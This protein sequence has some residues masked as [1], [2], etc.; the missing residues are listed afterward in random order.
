MEK[1]TNQDPILENEE[2]T[3]QESVVDDVKDENVDE[4]QEGSNEPES[5][6]ELKERLEALEKKNKELYGRLKRTATKT[7]KSKEPSV[8]NL[9]LM[10]HFSSGGT[11]DEVDIINTIMRGDG[12]N[13]NEAKKSP[14]YVSYLE[15]KKADK[16]SEDSQVNSKRVASSSEKFKKGLTPDE[17][18]EAWK[19]KMATILK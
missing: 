12:V 2:Q 13:F 5:T 18:K 1:E 10:E 17:H 3:F 19:E 16:A 11:R 14:L 15:K 8:D 9:D 4:L 6:E 7:N